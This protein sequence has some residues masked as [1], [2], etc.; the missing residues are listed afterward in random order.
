MR[1]KS[2]MKAHLRMVPLI[3]LSH[4]CRSCTAAS[5]RVIPATT[6]YAMCAPL[7]HSIGIEGIDADQFAEDAHG[8]PCRIPLSTNRNRG[9]SFRE[10]LHTAE[11]CA[12]GAA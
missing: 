7:R 8:S 3:P 5:W 2:V 6:C 1:L 10:Q 9:I 11:H 12:V 4:V